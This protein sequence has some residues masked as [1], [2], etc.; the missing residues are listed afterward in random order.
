MIIK[1]YY[2][3]EHVNMYTHYTHKFEFIYLNVIARS[4]RTQHMSN[5]NII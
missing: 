5:D 2:Y 1:Y 4:T 3:Y